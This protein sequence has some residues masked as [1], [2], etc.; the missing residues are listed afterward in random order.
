[1]F[2]FA[3]MI[4][5]A[6]QLMEKI[7]QIDKNSD[8][9]LSKKW[10]VFKSYCEKTWFRSIVQIGIGLCLL[11]TLIFT[12]VSIKNQSEYNQRLLQPWLLPAPIG[13]VEILG[14]SIIYGVVFKNKGQSPAFN[15]NAGMKLNFYDKFPCF[16]SDSTAPHFS[17]FPDDEKV[18]E[19]QQRLT[20][21]DT[22]GSPIEL[23]ADSI[24]KLIE[25]SKAFLHVYLY[26][27]DYKRREH[28]F[29]FTFSLKINPRPI[30]PNTYYCVWGDINQLY[31]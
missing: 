28:N 7:K 29:L 23:P 21:K 26:Y 6:R 14:D 8:V 31:W 22:K 9:W 16:I 11:T 2:R 4:T 5:Y 3:G 15:G 20:Y 30:E 10:S 25:K 19:K 1:M 12:C 24:M 18:I 17:L 27:E 13:K